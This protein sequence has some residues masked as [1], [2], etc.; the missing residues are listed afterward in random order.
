M[1]N[2][3]L[4]QIA[5]IEEN[6]ALAILQAKYNVEDRTDWAMDP[7]K[8]YAMD[9]FL[10]DLK[11]AIDYK[12][13]VLNTKYNTFCLQWEHFVKYMNYINNQ[14]DIDQGFLW[15]KDSISLKNFKINLNDLYRH[16]FSSTIPLKQGNSLYTKYSD[17]GCFFPIP[18]SLFDTIDVIE[19]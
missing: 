6:Q 18:I 19:F 7:N 17:N 10:P 15:Y 2:L 3:T 8:I 14:D 16:I 13:K 1:S 11:I 4:F 9:F 5:K 12:Y